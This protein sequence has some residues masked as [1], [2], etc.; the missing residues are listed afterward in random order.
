MECGFLG[1][2]QVLYKIASN[3]HMHQTVHWLILLV[4]MHMHVC[5]HTGN[6]FGRSITCKEGESVSRINVYSNEN[7]MLPFHDRS[8]PLQ[9][10]S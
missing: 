6:S 4:C 5:T 1:E 10:A 3:S 2:L 9:P 8:D 7:K